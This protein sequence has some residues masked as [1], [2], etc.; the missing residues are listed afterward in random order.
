MT[1]ASSRSQ[2]GQRL[3]HALAVR[4]V[5]KRALGDRLKGE[6]PDGVTRT[7]LGYYVT[8]KF[9]PTVDMAHTIAH[10]LNVRPAWL[11]AGDGEMTVTGTEP[12]AP[13]TPE[14]LERMAAELRGLAAQ[15]RGS[16]A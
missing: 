9:S 13:T 2:F 5:S 1:A 14:A 15:L 7:T 11:L 8:G 16:G 12:A 6:T 10:V 4:G 3:A